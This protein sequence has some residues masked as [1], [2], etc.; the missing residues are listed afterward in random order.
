M[1]DWSLQG[2][3]QLLTVQPQAS[4]TPGAVTTTKVDLATTG[5]GHIPATE[6]F[7]CECSGGASKSGLDAKDVIASQA[8]SLIDNWGK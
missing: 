1:A 7:G 8:Q 6:V 4:A 5:S 3:S 2:F